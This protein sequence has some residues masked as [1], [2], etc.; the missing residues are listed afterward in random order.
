[1]T[2]LLRTAFSALVITCTVIVFAQDD[3]SPN[4]K[5][6]IKRAD[7]SVAAIV[8]IPDSQR[9]Y[10]NTI[11]AIDDLQARLDGDVTF[12]VFMQNVSPDAKIR[13]QSRAADEYVSNWETEEG[14]R[15][16][17][18]RAVKAY[19]DTKPQ[20]KTEQDRLLKF[21]LR[22]YHRAGMD[23]SPDQRGKLKQIELQENKAGISFD[24]NIADDETTVPL[25]LAELKGVPK[26][27]VNRLQ[28]S[29]GFYLVT[30]DAPTFDAILDHDDVENARQRVWLEYKRRGGEKNVKVLQLL[31]KLR[32]DEAHILGYQ[33]Y[34]DYATEPRM[35]KNA[36]TVTKFY[37][38]L[39][40]VV[41]KKAKLDYDEFLAAKRKHTGDAKASLYPW[42]VSY[43]KNILEQQK[44]A[45]DE[46]KVSE[47]FPMERAV[48]GLFSVTQPLYGLTYK[49][50]TAQADALHLPIWYSDVKL[51]EVDDNATHQ[52]LGYFYLD[53]FPR[54][55]KYSHFATWGLIS[56]KLWP[57][58]SIRKPVAA[59]V[60]NFTKPTGGKPSLLPHEEV[61]TLFHE[62]GHCLHNILTEANTTRFAGTSVELDFVEA[63]S[64]MFENWVWSPEVLR[65]FA[66]N[67]KTGQPLP[68]SLLKGMLAARYL[69]SGLDAEHQFYYGIVDMKYHMVPD[70][71]VD[72][73]KI[74]IDTYPE[75]EL[76]SRIP[77]TF[78]EASFDHLN[79]YAAGYYGYMWSLVY[80]QDMFQRFKQ[81]GL[82]NPKAGMYYREKILSRGGTVDAMDMVRDY[83]GREPKM[84]SFLEHLGLKPGK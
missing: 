58:G 34:A 48:S 27:V 9:T 11:G 52:I 38:D 57:D 41:R 81:L 84:D 64:Q 72:T 36:A 49:D 51:Y 35:A 17:L 37:T 4:V 42:D 80:A 50:V 8:A 71:N 55:G 3:V 28:Q 20:L 79:G 76:Y 22:D 40:P 7:D 44:Y 53:M 56:R 25:T 10:E 83:L 30:M 16:D 62:F 29:H 47:Y 54:T 23:L 15:E 59:L 6:A 18:Y 66:R 60:C 26:D 46:T 82:L 24:Q 39:Q 74:G 78:F 33:S 1:M 45:V 32:A 73:T 13:D 67:Y 21:M 5:A 12:D 63:P 14:K 2:K 65:T 75:V 70:G 43:Y 19:A 77:G 69:G 68:E 61:E 31:L